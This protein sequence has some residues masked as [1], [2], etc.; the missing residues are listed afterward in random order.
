[1]AVLA[2]SVNESRYDGGENQLAWIWNEITPLSPYM[3]SFK[4][5]LG[6]DAA[7]M[8]AVAIVTVATC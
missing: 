4:D 7:A 3:Y 8:R 5:R 2:I 1:L 6:R